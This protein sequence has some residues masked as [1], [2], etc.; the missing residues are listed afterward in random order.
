MI[1]PGEPLL[2]V[3]DN[4]TNRDVLSRRL[5]RHGYTVVGAA[6]GREAL[7][8]VDAQPFS[9]LLLDIEMPGMSGLEVLQTLRRRYSAAELPIIMVTARQ[10]SSDVVEALGLGAN[11]YV[12]K[13][14]DLPI[15]LAR[16]QTQLSRKQAE[17]ALQESEER[18][19]LAVR[20]AN[21]GL[22]DWNLRTN[23]IYFSPRWKYMIGC[24]ES[25][26]T[27]SPDEWIK[28][29]HPEDLDRVLADIAAHTD[30]LTPQFENQHRML[31]ADGSYRW[32]L[33]RGVAVRDANGKAHRMAGSQTDITEGKVS[34]PLTGLPNRI[35]FMDRLRR[36]LERT[37][38]HPGYLF[39]VLF[40]DLDRFKLINDSR[41]HLFG[42][43]LLIAIAQRLE[44]CLRAADTVARLGR[45][46]TLARLGGDEFTILL[47]DIRHVS[48]AVRVA[49]RIQKNLETPF[50]LD[51]HETFTSASIGIATSATGYDEPEEL[52]RDADTA[53]YR[54]KALG[55]ARCELFDASMREAAVAR[56]AM[57]TDLRRAVEREEFRLHY[58]PIVSLATGAITGFEALIRWQH[59][60]RGLVHA[61]GFHPGRGGD[62]IHPAH[63]LVGSPRSVPADANVGHARPSRCAA[64]HQRESVWQT[65]RTV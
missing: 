53:M 37:V 4:E 14:I 7:D 50:Q 3:D 54:A 55:K 26:V 20:G 23:V 12:A 34:D 46:H 59:P 5:Q 2:I 41:G 29:V 15:T 57:E 18:Y 10:E 35:L 47:D 64:D 61:R 56:L 28:R 49:D 21:D 60:E 1:V 6:S 19:A 22:W 13:P 45:D 51:G 31:H 33:S 42:D 17:A 52:L 24:D 9:L 32:M 25:G 39:A 62:R 36:S 65:V 58:Q 27:G 43:R 48:D 63:R 11:D 40:L 38:R 44:S 8:L 30:G 16:I